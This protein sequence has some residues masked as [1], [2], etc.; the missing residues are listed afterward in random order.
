ME[1]ANIG[2]DGN[3]RKKII[4]MR[5]DTADLDKLKE[6]AK[7]LR[8]RDSTFLRFAIKSALTKL[9][10]LHD[11]TV[12]GKYLIPMMMDTGSDL[13]Q[14]FDIDNT[15]LETII[16]YQLRDKE[17]MVDSEDIALLAMGKLCDSYHYMKLREL[18]DLPVDPHALDESFREYLLNKY[19]SHSDTET[20]I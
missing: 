8:V 1:K 5:I 10:P 2:M 7:R 4:S 13:V 20:D 11:P 3:N 18:S 14:H 9:E 17:H 12:S 6:I 15:R 19:S 16:N